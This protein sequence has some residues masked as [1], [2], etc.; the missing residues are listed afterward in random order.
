MSIERYTTVIIY[1]YMGLFLLFLLI[2][3]MEIWNSIRKKTSK[4]WRGMIPCSILYLISAILST[5]AASIAYNDPADPNYTRYG[6]WELRDFILHDIRTLIVWLVIGMLF[7]LAAKRPSVKRSTK[8]KSIK[9][10]C[11]MLCAISFILLLILS[12]VKM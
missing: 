3:V 2:G 9:I 7:Y 6:G 5:F 10:G 1:L 8:P 11:A 4:Y 12:T